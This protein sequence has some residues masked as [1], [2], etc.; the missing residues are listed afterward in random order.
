MR[1]AWTSATGKTA[2]LCCRI[3]VEICCWFC[4]VFCF[5]TLPLI[6]CSS[7][8]WTALHDAACDGHTA[9]CELLIAGK[10]DVDAKDR[11]AFIFWIWYWF[12]VV[13]CFLTLPLI[14]CSSGQRTALHDAAL[15]GR[16][17]VC[18]LLIAGKADVDAKNEC[19]FM[20]W[21]CCWF[22][23]VFCFLTLPL[24]FRSSYQRTALHWAVSIGRTAVCELL[25]AGKADVNAKERCAF[26]FWICYWL[27]VV[28][29]FLT[30]LLIFCSSDQSTALH[31]AA[32]NGH[33]AV[34]ELLIAGK[35]DVNAKDHLCA[36]IFWICYWFCVVF[37]F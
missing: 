1:I 26:I 24:I 17:A 35:A 7:D 22:C 12:C 18:E 25:I 37:R 10:A 15:Y 3:C 2:L 4:V 20:F 9:V 11:C 32:R 36:F 19:A 27:C 31:D 23:V 28:Y 34:C 13:F 16:T 29:C 30:L 8:Q 21:I 14:F 5:L 6:F 33:P